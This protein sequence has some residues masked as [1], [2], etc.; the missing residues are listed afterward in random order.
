MS[1]RLS[2]VGKVPPFEASFGPTG[3]LRQEFGT[4]GL[5]HIDRD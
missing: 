2:L 4:Q 1:A 5:V 3:A